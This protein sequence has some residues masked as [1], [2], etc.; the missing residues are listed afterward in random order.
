MYKYF[1]L[2]LLSSFFIVS[3]KK[4]QT[5]DQKIQD[6]IASKQLKMQST[7]EGVYYS[8]DS[9]GTGTTM[10]ASTD[11]VYATYQLSLL[12]GTLAGDTKTVPDTFFLGNTLRGLQIG[13]QKFTK[14]ARGKIII[15]SALGLG[16]TPFGN[17]PVNSILIF[18]TK[19]VDFE[20]SDENS[21]IKKFLAQKGWNNYKT[22]TEGLYYIIDSLGTGTAMPTVSSEVTV[23]YKG[24]LLNGTVFDSNDLGYTSTLN[25]LIKGWQIGIPFFKKG[26]KGKLVMPSS[27]GY[28]SQ[29][30]GII[31][32]NSPL[33]FEIELVSF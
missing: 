29:A 25:K 14:G 15:P 22:T 5:D 9:V 7:S 19:V 4:E 23:K 21:R 20:P 28:G 26:G 31:P 30:T 17:I 18:D 12:D 27:L 3:C 32:A 6:Y 13:F 24:Y 2:L 8:I 10:P 16:I 33:V 1:A 11:I